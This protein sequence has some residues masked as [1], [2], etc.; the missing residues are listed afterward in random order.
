MRAKVSK[1]MAA[2]R[3]TALREKLLKAVQKHSKSPHNIWDK[4]RT[5]Y[6]NEKASNKLSLSTE[7]FGKNKLKKESLM[8]PI[9]EPESSFTKLGIVGRPVNELMGVSILLSTFMSDKNYEA[10]VAPI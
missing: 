8:D 9:A 4:M 7:A 10:V 5:K 3:T 1:K 2:V 6:A